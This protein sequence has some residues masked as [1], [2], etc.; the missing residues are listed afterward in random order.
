MNTVEIPDYLVEALANMRAKIARRD[1]ARQ[2]LDELEEECG[3][4]SR[5]FNTK[6]AM[7][8]CG[9]DR[10]IEELSAPLVDEAVRS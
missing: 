6:R 9:L 3:V 1:A 4:A 7:F 2:I 5:E 10:H 8:L